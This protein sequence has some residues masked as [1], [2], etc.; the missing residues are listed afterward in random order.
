M[1]PVPLQADRRKLSGV[2]V[3]VK[4]GMGP[5]TLI[6]GLFFGEDVDLPLN[7]VVHFM[8]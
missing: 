4:A 5:I 3:P 1:Y 8:N 6:L 7:I 2:F